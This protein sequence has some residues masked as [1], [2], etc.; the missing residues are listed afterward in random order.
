[1]ALPL[2]PLSERFYDAAGP[3]SAR[4]ILD[5]FKDKVTGLNRSPDLME[6]IYGYYAQR[7]QGLLVHI[8]FK[9]LHQANLAI[10][11]ERG[12]EF[13]AASLKVIEAE[14][15]KAGATT[16]FGLRQRGD[17]IGILVDGIDELQLRTAMDRAMLTMRQ[18]VFNCGD[19][20]QLAHRKLGREPGLGFG[21]VVKPILPDVKA[22]EAMAQLARELQ[23][24]K[25]NY[26]GPLASTVTPEHFKNASTRL[27][28]DKGFLE[29]RNSVKG[30]SVS[31]H[32]P[33]A[34]LDAVGSIHCE[35]VDERL[36]H[37]QALIHANEDDALFRMDVRGL[38]V[39]NS[40]EDIGRIDAM[41]QDF[42]ERAQNMLETLYS[43]KSVR[44]L[45]V[46]G[47]VMDAILPSG[48]ARQRHE[49][50]VQVMRQFEEA[51]KAH[52]FGNYI[53][54]GTVGLC[55]MESQID[56][57]DAF[58]TNEHL[59]QLKDVMRR[60][61]IDSI[62]PASEGGYMVTMRDTRL[63]PFRLD[64]G[65]GRF[66]VTKIVPLLYRN[67]VERSYLGREEVVNLLTMPVGMVASQWFG[68]DVSQA[69]SANVMIQK[70]VRSGLA[71]EEDFLSV[72]DD[73]KALLA[74]FEAGG[75]AFRQI[76]L[77]DATM[78]TNG[79]R[80][81]ELATLS[82]AKRWGLLPAEVANMVLCGQLAARTI[83]VS[84]SEPVTRTQAAEILKKDLKP[85]IRTGEAKDIQ[86]AVALEQSAKILSAV[87][88]YLNEPDLSA[89]HAVS[90]AGFLLLKHTAYNALN[91]EEGKNFGAAL[92]SFTSNT[93]TSDNSLSQSTAAI[94]DAL[95]RAQQKMESADNVLCQSL[96]PAITAC[97][98]IL[99]QIAPEMK[100]AARVHP[101]ARKTSP[102]VA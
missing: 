86:F 68:A 95:N 101:A 1:M 3:V 99:E 18:S 33:D 5:G 13:M 22:A 11:Q 55:L 58:V 52:G 92:S 67:L 31:T 27:A 78:L 17:E 21:Y 54:A 96:R 85:H 47:G 28:V 16:R 51:M 23:G 42:K 65:D 83:K 4:V 100:A 12:D 39:L 98:E 15:V 24:I 53:E 38:S 77:T 88:S 63:E 10:G 89:R 82:L 2:Q 7:G 36:R 90:E 61:G 94:V 26:D 72:S 29:M 87:S 84:D 30:K 69:V 70:L 6:A 19:L 37:A 32:V 80:H 25:S 20:W 45:P 14:L 34:V 44:I 66:D 56:P 40:I 50:H 41:L 43:E 60:C 81:A 48:D 75:H 59:D 57:Q 102:T 97:C 9:N 71:R 91:S 35:L 79:V 8:D 46:S 93:L 64:A 76:S 62:T 49:A 74:A 73:R